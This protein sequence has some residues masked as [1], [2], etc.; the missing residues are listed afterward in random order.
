MTTKTELIAALTAAGIEYN[1][2]SEEYEDGEIRCTEQVKAIEAERGEEFGYNEF[3][4]ALITDSSV[5][6][7]SIRNCFSIDD[8]TTVPAEESVAKIKDILDRFYRA[9]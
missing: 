4:G 8:F 6:I 7:V 5:E 3:M 1:D 9:A 2:T